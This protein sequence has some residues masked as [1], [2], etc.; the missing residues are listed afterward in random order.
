MRH[1]LK[2]R[3]LGR[4]SEHRQALLRNLAIALVEHQQIRTTLPKAKELRPF[5]ER[6]VTIARKNTLHTRRLL[7]ARLGNQVEAVD[8]LIQLAV[9]EYKNR[10]GGYTRIYKCGFRVGDS[11]PMGLI[12]FVGNE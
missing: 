4:T 11:A 9:G 1:R 2:G 3:K 12:E 10:D 5:V 6:L 7:L 8:K